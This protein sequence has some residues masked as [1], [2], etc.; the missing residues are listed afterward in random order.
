MKKR[1]EGIGIK[2]MFVLIGATVPAVMVGFFNPTL[3]A[4]IFVVL[5]S[6]FL[7]GTIIWLVILFRS[8]E[9]GEDS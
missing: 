4:R 1:I 3:M 6:I 9:W 7:A 8:I 5:G 2:A